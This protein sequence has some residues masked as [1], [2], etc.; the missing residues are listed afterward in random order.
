MSIRS[1]SRR[2]LGGPIR[3]ALYDR[4]D[5][6]PEHLADLRKSGLADGTIAQQKI[7]SVPPHMID[8]LLGFQVAWV[9]GTEGDVS[10]FLPDGEDGPR[11]VR[12][13]AHG[14]SRSSTAIRRQSW[15]S[16]SPTPEEMAVELARAS[17]LPPMT[18]WCWS[19][20]LS[21]TNSFTGSTSGSQPGQ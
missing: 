14:R 7:R 3:S 8:K 19:Q 18:G 12:D 6:H 16:A 1:S 11:V 10:G 20:R 15:P 17:S 9:R 21:W 4:S 13:Q 2:H 5:F